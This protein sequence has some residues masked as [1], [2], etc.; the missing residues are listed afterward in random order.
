MS[1]DDTSGF[2]GGAIP[3]VKFSTIGDRIRAKVTAKEV[4]QQTDFDTGRLITWP[5]GRPKLQAVLTVVLAPDQRDDAEDDG[6]R[7]L[8]IRGFMQQDFVAAVKAAK[9]TD[10]PIGATVDVELTTIDPPKQPN[11]N[12]AQHYAVQVWGPGQTPEPS[13]APF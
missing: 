8:Y 9:L 1:Q 3:A 7:M 4:R 12:G 6:C 5:D 11:Q 10:V 13:S 2:F